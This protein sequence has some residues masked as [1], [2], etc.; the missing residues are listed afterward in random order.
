VALAVASL[1]TPCALLAFTLSF[2]S[3]AA[4]LRWTT[5]FFVSTGFFS[6]WQVWLGGA[7]VLLVLARVLGQQPPNDSE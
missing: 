2:W 3:I 4:D 5:A 7:A 1:L 6:H